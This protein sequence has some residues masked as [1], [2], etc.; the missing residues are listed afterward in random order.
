MGRSHLRRIG[1]IGGGQ[2]GLMLGEA[3]RGIGAEC[4]FLEP[5][6]DPPAGRVGPV[7]PHPY[8]DPGGLRELAAQVEVIT[9]ETENVPAD[10]IA[11]LRVSG[12]DLAAAAAAP[13]GRDVLVRPPPLALRHG[14]DRLRE[15]RLFRQLKI[16][17]AEFLAVTG[18]EDLAARRPEEGPTA[19]RAGALDRRTGGR[20]RLRGL[21]LRRP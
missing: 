15:K 4:W 9:Y 8:D 10:A 12:G 17:T 18:Q 3:G 7:L 16:P 2:L 11:S 20:F 13:V 21:D 14:Q 19:G 5:A 1:I 6:A